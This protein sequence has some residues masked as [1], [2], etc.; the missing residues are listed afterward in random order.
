MSANDHDNRGTGPLGPD[1]HD[2]SEPE[3]PASASGPPAA[4]SEPTP[5]VAG[6]QALARALKGS[7]TV[8]KV[9]M[10]AL[11]LFYFA[12]GVF[13]VEP[14][15]VKFKLLFGAVERPGGSPA[16]RS[17]KIYFRLPGEKIEVVSTE[18]RT[19]D[20]G[21]EFW[22]SPPM[23]LGERKNSLDVRKDG[24]LITGDANIVHMKLRVR[25]RVRHD[26]D[27]AMSYL[28]AVKD[29]EEILKRALMESAVKT[30]GSMEIMEILKRQNI[31]DAVTADLQGRVA[32]FEKKA[33]VPLGIEVGAVEAIDTER[34]K[35]P[36][37]PYVVRE[38]FAEAQNASALRD[39]LVEEG[40]AQANTILANAQA[41]A[42]EIEA[43]ASGRRALLVEA[44]RADAKAL[45]QLL[46]M[47]SHS[48][49]EAK[50]LR[51]TFYERTIRDVLQGAK[52]IFVLYQPEPG[53]QR[54][55]RLL[56]SKP[57]SLGR[58]AKKPAGAPK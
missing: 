45:E 55:L 16:L 32:D 23:E 20:L 7:F 33:G 51:E 40:R 46:P 52:G 27:G 54:E 2:H 41:Q 25:Y 49:E 18:E 56:L 5:E 38:A 53:T 31:L 57:P 1:A 47:Y 26:A 58:A 37:E 8:L 10:I 12:T 15:E 50:I 44:A 6:S 29:P 3:P 35:N 39:Q 17:G 9:G 48:P 34:M 28:F 42:T 4:A 24:Y 13:K 22:T 11:V 19:L 30:V 36:C 21:Q 14:Q 43:E